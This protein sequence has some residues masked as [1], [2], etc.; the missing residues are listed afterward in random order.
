MEADT[1]PWGFWTATLKMGTRS[2]CEVSPPSTAVGGGTSRDALA[3][4]RM[5]RDGATHL[6][7]EFTGCSLW[8]PLHILQGPH[9]HKWPH[10]TSYRGRSSSLGRF[11]G[12]RTLPKCPQAALY[13]PMP[14]VPTPGCP[15]HPGTLRLAICTSRANATSSR[16]LLLIPQDGQAAQPQLVS[17]GLTKAAGGSLL[18]SSMSHCC[19]HLV[20]TWSC[21]AKPAG[22][23]TG[24]DGPFTPQRPRGSLQSRAWGHW[25]SE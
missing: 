17:S 15:L 1:S 10:F 20:T 4:V 19:S 23:G 7:I 25:C 8:A 16:K 13:L 5:R 21:V 18:S 22:R 9:C 6:P 11:P 3:G 24:W 14:T 12:C 2:G